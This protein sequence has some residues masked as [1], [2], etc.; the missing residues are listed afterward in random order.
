MDIFN[1][2]QIDIFIRNGAVPIGAGTGHRFKVYITFK[3]N[4][5]FKDLMERWLNKEF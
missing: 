3:E 2:K 1:I 5:I 4:Q